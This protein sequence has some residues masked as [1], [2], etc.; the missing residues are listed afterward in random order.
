MGGFETQSSISE[1]RQSYNLLQIPPTMAKNHA[2][3]VLAPY[4]LAYSSL[5]AGEVESTRIYL[6][7]ML[8]AFERLAPGRDACSV[9][10]HYILLSLL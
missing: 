6:Q 7:E 8:L 2:G 10:L 1:K 5:V 9:T 4:L 3:S